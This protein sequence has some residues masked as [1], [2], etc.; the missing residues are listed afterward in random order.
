[1]AKKNA[2]RDEPLEVTEYL[3]GVSEGHRNC[4]EDLRELILEL[5]PE[6]TQRVSYGIP[7]FRLDKDLVGISSQKGHCSFHTMS[8][9]LMKSMK[10]ECRAWKVSGATIQFSSDNPLNEEIVKIIL[11][12]RIKEIQD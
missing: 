5:V 3:S 12:A 2:D 8:P 1:M 4:L 9:E 11:T 6:A 10:N 7:I